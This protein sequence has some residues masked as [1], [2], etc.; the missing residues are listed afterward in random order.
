MPVQPISPLGSSFVPYAHQYQQLFFGLTSQKVNELWQYNVLYLLHFVLCTEVV[1][2]RLHFAVWLTDS[3]SATSSWLPVLQRLLFG[4]ILKA[5]LIT[6][7]F[8]RFTY[9]HPVHFFIQIQVTV[10]YEDSS[11]LLDEGWFFYVLIISVPLD[12]IRPILIL[13][14]VHKK[15]D[16]DFRW[17]HGVK[18][19]DGRWKL[20]SRRKGESRKVAINA[21]W[22]R[23]WPGKVQK[24]F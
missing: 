9:P 7:S 3:I 22:S 18:A 5:N 17:V 8:P 10:N 16:V 2:K 4:C 6:L 1:R 23:S 11:F 14:S 20:E 24:I 13:T 12:L 19:T 15:L 21:V